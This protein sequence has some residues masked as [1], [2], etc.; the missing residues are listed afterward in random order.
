MLCRYYIGIGCAVRVLCAN[1]S[2]EWAW[3]HQSLLRD[4]EAV[5]PM[6]HFMLRM[7]A[8]KTIPMPGDV[9]LLTGGPPCQVM[10]K[11]AVAWC[12]VVS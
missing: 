6:R 5:L 2:S 4:K 10:H 11:P 9:G 7:L 12:R 1:R 3:E 8:D